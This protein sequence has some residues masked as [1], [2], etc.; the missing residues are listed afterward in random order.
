MKKCVWMSK[1]QNLVTIFDNLDPQI[2]LVGG[3][4]SKAIRHSWS[5]SHSSLRW[6][7]AD[8]SGY[9]SKSE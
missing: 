9:D 8:Y 6:Q 5:K 3:V 4:A 2:D 1:Q 7:F